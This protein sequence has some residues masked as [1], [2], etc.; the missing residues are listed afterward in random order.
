M[1]IRYAMNIIRKELLNKHK[2][3]EGTVS[4]TE[5]LE[6]EHTRYAGF[7]VL[8]DGI[9]R[10]INL[11]TEKTDDYHRYVILQVVDT[12][13]NKCKVKLT[14]YY[15]FTRY[16]DNFYNIVKEMKKDLKLS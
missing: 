14:K 5:Y 3:L 8:G 16:N 12:K 2:K 13:D 4:K 9:T 7:A 10:D 1:D 11:E 15:E 6:T